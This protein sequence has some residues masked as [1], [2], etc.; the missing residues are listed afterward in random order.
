M[1]EKDLTLTGADKSAGGDKRGRQRRGRFEIGKSAEPEPVFT[2][3]F[4]HSG[5]LCSFC[6]VAGA[7]VNCQ[8]P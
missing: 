8:Q 3:G 6:S 2:N 7:A 4:T 1:L 5:T